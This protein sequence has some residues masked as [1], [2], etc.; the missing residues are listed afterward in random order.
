MTRIEAIE[1]FLLRGGPAMWVI[2]ALSVLMVT[3]VLWRIWRLSLAGAWSGGRAEAL[4][5]DLCAGAD[6]ATLP[7]DA[8][9]VRPRFV[10]DCVGVLSEPGLDRG[11]QQAEITRLAMLEIAGLR[12]GL[13]PLDLIATI[14]PL[15]GLLGTVLG[16]IDAFQALQLAG[17]TVDATLLAGGIWQA[18]LTTAAGMAVAIP[19]TIAHSWFEAVADRVQA[20]LEGIATRLFACFATGRAKV[21]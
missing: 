4:V 11:L 21:A 6:A 20:D 8:R 1:G 5:T 12:H 13:R 15:V 3:L 2:A 16:M 14:A 17:D 9:R 7:L 10:R 19:A 18:L